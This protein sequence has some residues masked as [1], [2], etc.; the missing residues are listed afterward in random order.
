M[1]AQV[2]QIAEIQR[3]DAIRIF[4]LEKR[5]QSLERRLDRFE[6]S[7]STEERPAQ[8]DEELGRRHVGDVK[9]VKGLIK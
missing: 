6:E 4:A 7:H 8:G 5:V 1:K 2:R 3:L 9:Q